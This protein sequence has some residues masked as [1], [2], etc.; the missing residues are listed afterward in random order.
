MLPSPFPPQ[1]HSTNTGLKKKEEW[2][3]CEIACGLLRERGEWK[4]EKGQV[5]SWH[6]LENDWQNL[7]WLPIL[8]TCWGAKKQ[9]WRGSALGG[10]TATHS[11]GDKALQWIGHLPPWW[12]LWTGLA[13]WGPWEYL[14]WRLPPKEW[15]WA[16]TG[17]KAY[18]INLLRDVTSLLSQE[19]HMRHKLKIVPHTK[20]LLSVY[21]FAY[22]TLYISTQDWYNLSEVR[23]LLKK[24]CFPRCHRQKKPKSIKRNFQFLNLCPKPQLKPKHTD[25][26]SSFLVFL[27]LTVSVLI[28]QMTLK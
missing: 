6:E 14:D 13:T 23:L 20:I 12:W 11:L 19:E 25:H 15:L 5:H 26:E 2:R 4:K 28:S 10:H 7:S 16:I 24:N 9:P 22:S 3:L 1:Y 21:L 8:K 18:L 17:M 27:V